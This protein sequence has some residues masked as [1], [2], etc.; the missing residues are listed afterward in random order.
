MSIVQGDADKYEK[1]QFFMKY[2][3]KS[4]VEIADFIGVS[5]EH[6]YKYIK[7]KRLSEDKI[8]QI[9]TFIGVSRDQLE[10]VS[11]SSIRK[12]DLPG[13]VRGLIKDIRDLKTDMA[14]IKELVLQN[15]KDGQ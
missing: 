15:K 12:E 6:M 1:L 10:D 2:S 4:G 9:L 5:R 13:I 11:F 7:E 8:D 14:L 3:D